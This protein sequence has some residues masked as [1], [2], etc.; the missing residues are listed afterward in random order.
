MRR[1]IHKLLRDSAR[2]R[3]LLWIPGLIA[4]SS[5]PVV[6]G[7]ASMDFLQSRNPPPV[8]GTPASGT[9]PKSRIL[10]VDDQYVPPPPPHHGSPH[11]PTAGH[12]GDG[13]APAASGLSDHGGT[14]VRPAHGADGMLLDIRT[15]PRTGVIRED[16]MSPDHGLISSTL[17]SI[18]TNSKPK[19]R[20]DSVRDSKKKSSTANDGDHKTE[21][22]SPLGGFDPLDAHPRFQWFTPQN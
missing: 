11:S 13:S 4:V 2:A 17:V 8:T 19:S 12:P 3:F 20:D 22:V 14:D 7:C 21:T 9:T 5:A 1:R 10:I 15:A 16:L 6:S 18:G